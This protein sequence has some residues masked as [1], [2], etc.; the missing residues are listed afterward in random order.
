MPK[1]IIL[2]G[3][4][5]VGKTTIE[6]EIER[7]VAFKKVDP[8]SLMGGKGILRKHYEEV[9]APEADRIL[10]EGSNALITGIFYRQI[11]DH[12][13]D[14]VRTKHEPIIINLYC[15]IEELLRRNCKRGKNVPEEEIR[16]YYD[17]LFKDEDFMKGSINTQELSIDEVASKA[18]RMIAREKGQI[19]RR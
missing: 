11:L 2:R 13:L 19:Y 8:D 10:R 18:C 14:H 3:P 15:P 6:K 16:N 17:L 1:L 7:T 5:G 12:F 4:P 9:F